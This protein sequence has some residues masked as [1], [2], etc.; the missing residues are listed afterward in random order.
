MRCERAPWKEWEEYY[1][2]LQKCRNN[3]SVLDIVVWRIDYN[4]ILSREKN[5]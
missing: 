5:E 1:S 3:S 4:E 2:S